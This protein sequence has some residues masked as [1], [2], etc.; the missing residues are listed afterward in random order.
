MKPRKRIITLK[1]SARDKDDPKAVLE[2][3]R[4]ALKRS[5]MTLR[6]TSCEQGE[7]P[8]VHRQIA[9]EQLEAAAFNLAAKHLDEKARTI[10]KSDEE[11]AA[12][13]SPKEAATA[14]KKVYDWIM[15]KVKVGYVITVGAILDWIKGQTTKSPD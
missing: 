6:V 8:E 2:A 12:K 4:E 13:P 5:G 7:E 1:L 14:R 3:V 15:G 9:Q 10:A 11:G